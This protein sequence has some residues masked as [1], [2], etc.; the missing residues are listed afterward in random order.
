M[1]HGDDRESIITRIDTAILRFVQ[2]A[3]SAHVFGAEE[4][5]RLTGIRLTAPT[6]LV[7]ER[8]STDV[9]RV[10]DLAA[11]VGVTPGVV[12][13]QLQ[14]L[15]ARG[16]VERV[17]SA[18]D[19]RASPVRLT[20]K[21]LEIIGTAAD[22]RRRFVRRLLDDWPEGDPDQIAETLERLGAAVILEPSEEMRSTPRPE[23]TRSS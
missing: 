9:M 4:M 18:R 15:E 22:L 13:R 20:S 16:L 19:R 8:L 7:M 10:T 2:N 17:D 3:Q 5:T 21:G 23:E 1:H 6:L 11:A 12:S 14:D